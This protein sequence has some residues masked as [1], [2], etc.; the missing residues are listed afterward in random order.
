MSRAFG[1]KLEGYRLSARGDA[2]N[3]EAADEA[4]ARYA[5]ESLAQQIAYERG[6]LRP[7]TI[8]DSPRFGFRGLHLDLARNFHSKSEVLKL[9]DQMARYKLNKLHLHLGDDEGWRLRD[10]ALARA[11]R[12]RRLPLLRPE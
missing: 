9:V 5:L 12:G 10:R 3:V 7:I 6:T 2:I 1:L 11:N 4:G 8:E